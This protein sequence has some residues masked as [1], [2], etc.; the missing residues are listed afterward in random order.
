MNAHC[1]SMVLNPPLYPASRD[2]TEVKPGRREKSVSVIMEQQALL[3]RMEL[4]LWV[5]R[6]GCMML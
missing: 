2:G 6:S 1:L 4:I 3:Q 5:E